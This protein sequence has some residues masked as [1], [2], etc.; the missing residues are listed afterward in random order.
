MN[1][2]TQQ[3]ERPFH[4]TIVD[5]IGDAVTLG[6]LGDLIVRTKIPKNHDAI[7][8]AWERA[9]EQLEQADEAGIIGVLLKKKQRAEEEA[10]KKKEEN[11]AD[12]EAAGAFLDG[13]TFKRTL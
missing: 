5:A 6:S 3:E 9:L 13:E 10:H 1:G 8:E 12:Q 11:P 4:E 2:E 7:I